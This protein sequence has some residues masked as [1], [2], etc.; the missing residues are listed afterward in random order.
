MTQAQIAVVIPAYNEAQ[1]VADVVRAAL[2]LTP[3][4]IVASDGSSDDT[5]SVARAAGARVV[6]LSV[7][8]GKGPALHA[9]L[10]ATDAEYV[11]MLDADLLG[12]TLAHLHIL[13]G[14]VLAG[15]LGMSIGIFDGGGLMTDL[16]NK[17]APHLSGQRACKRLWLLNVPGLGEERWP[18]PAITDAL[19]RGGMKWDYVELPGLKQVMKEE[20]RGFW[21]GV[22]HRSRMY[23]DLLGYR[24]RRKKGQRD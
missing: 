23:V 20:K 9:A 13:T 4:V 8:A 14:P 6:E 22:G 10:R 1:T 12:L 24:R 15:R 11:L 7:N 18:E 16:G 19:K 5:A 3:E 21:K 17:L 2:L